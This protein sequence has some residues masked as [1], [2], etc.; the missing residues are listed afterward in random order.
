MCEWLL[1]LGK[2]LVMKEPASRGAVSSRADVEARRTN[3]ALAAKREKE[4]RLMRAVVYDRY[5]P[6]DVLRLEE[7]AR[8]VPK[9]DEVL[10]KIHATTVNRTDCGWRSAK[11]FITRYFLGLRRPEV[12][13]K[14]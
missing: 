8:P 4:S 13:F 14:A 11:P 2:A 7:V 9:T 1:S 12:L 5:G 6:P 10:V 3:P